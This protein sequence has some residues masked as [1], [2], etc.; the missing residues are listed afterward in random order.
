MTDVLIS[1]MKKVIKK[2]DVLNLT[3]TKGQYKLDDEA[4]AE[5]YT[6]KTD[7]ARV[8]MDKLTMLDA[9]ELEDFLKAASMYFAEEG[10]SEGAFTNLA[11][12]FGKAAKAWSNR[13]GN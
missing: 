13:K 7:A 1:N 9:V 8:A 2:G 3:L 12:L 11:E 5:G 4:M 10:E 6:V